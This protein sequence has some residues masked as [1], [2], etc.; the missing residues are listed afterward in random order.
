MAYFDHYAKGQSTGIG[1]ML[2]RKTK[3]KEFQYLSGFLSKGKN[4]E[5]LE[6]GPGDGGL[7]SIFFQHGYSAYDITEPNDILREK[8][9][10]TGVRNAKKYCIPKLQEQDGSYDLIICSDVFEHL[11]DRNEAQLFIEEAFRV[12]KTDG[13][14]FIISPDF[15]EWKTDFYNCDF[16]HN[17]VTT[18]KRTMQL[19]SDYNIKTLSYRYNYCCFSGFFGY[20]ISKLIKVFTC[21]STGNNP[22]SKFYKL[23]LTFLRRFAII[24]MKFIN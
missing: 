10:Q 19:F 13:I 6:I 9:I 2:E 23:R 20:I 18:V 14:F 5:I 3:E 22:H 21:F 8:L 16:S 12:L 24:G 15:I 11:N 4:I 17:N 1:L 7:A